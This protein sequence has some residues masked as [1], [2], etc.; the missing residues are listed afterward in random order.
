MDVF[1]ARQDNI[2]NEQLS[3]RAFLQTPPGV[4]DQFQCNPDAVRFLDEIARCMTSKVIT[5][6]SQHSAMDCSV[7]D[8]DG[9]VVDVPAAVNGKDDMPW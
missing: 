9:S 2:P 3:K 6:S 4:S 5:S 1:S 8:L 7:M